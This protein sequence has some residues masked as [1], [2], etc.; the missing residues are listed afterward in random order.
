VDCPS[1][2]TGW[3][4]PTLVDVEAGTE[5]VVTS[6]P[7]LVEGALNRLVDGVV[8]TLVELDETTLVEGAETSGTDELTVTLVDDPSIELP[9]DCVLVTEVEVPSSVP[10]QDTPTTARAA[11]TAVNVAIIFLIIG[12][13]LSS[14]TP[15]CL[16]AGQ[17][18]FRTPSR[19]SQSLESSDGH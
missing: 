16:G 1:G 5:V 18:D 2:T 17:E 9:V 3:A 14:M 11:T 15:L 8:D 12:W 7:T 19:R 10:A 13:L 4:A 6:A